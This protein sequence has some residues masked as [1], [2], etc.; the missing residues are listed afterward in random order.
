VRCTAELRAYPIHDLAHVPCWHNGPEV[1]I[2]DAAHATSPSSGQGA[3][4][5]LEDAIGLAALIARH[6]DP[7]NALPHFV[8]HR[9]PRAERIVEEGQKRGRYKATRSALERWVRDLVVPVM[10]RRFVTHQSMDWIYGYRA[11]DVI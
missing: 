10:L 9:R 5:V 1:L 7:V 11:A 8:A 3:A 6:P 2:G 4:L